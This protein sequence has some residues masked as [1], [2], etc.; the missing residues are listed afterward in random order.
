MKTSCPICLSGNH[1]RLFQARDHHYGIS[2]QWWIRECSACGTY[3]LEDPPPSDE[4]SQLYPQETYY[5]YSIPHPSA[6]KRFLHNLVGYSRNS[7]EPRFTR[8]GR[9]LDFGCGA[10]ERLLEMRSQGWDCAGV[11]IS[12]RARAVAREHGLDVRS[13]ISGPNGFERGGFDY[14]RSNHS[15]E[16]VLDPGKV[17]KDMFDALKPGGTLFLG[18]PTVSSQSA[19]IFGP[20]WWYLTPPLHAFMPSSTG[21][22]DLVRRSG[23]V[24]SKM[25]T[26]SD[27]AGI[28]GSLQILL[29][30]STA[31]RSNQGP[32]FAFKP[33]LV[34]GY[35]IARLQDFFRVGDKLEI[36]AVKPR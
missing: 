36:V 20:H 15:L 32:I 24:V 26:H 13:E 35:W 11:E 8:P 33:F 25:R 29:N 16:H 1:S 31:R 22:A 27:H 9:V 21:L 23:F 10:G 6:L 4:L 5:S 18:T 28:A 17:L 30:R 3:F 19:R 2:G 34:A 12:S 14:V 7:G